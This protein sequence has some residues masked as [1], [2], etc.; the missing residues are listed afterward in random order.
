VFLDLSCE[1]P[2]PARFDVGL[3]FV[4]ISPAARAKLTALPQSA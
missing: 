1:L 3:K 2:A 4:E